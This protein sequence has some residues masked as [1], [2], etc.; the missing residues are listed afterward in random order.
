MSLRSLLLCS[1]DKVT[2]VLR[3]V[4]SDL[5]IGVEHCGDAESAVHKLTRR[6]YEAVIVDCGDD[7]VA[8]RVF[9][10]VRSAP[11]NRHAIAVALIDS[12]RDVQ[13]AFTLG[14]HFV[15]YKTIS[16]ERAKGSFRAAR[17]LMKC[18]RRR[19]TRVAI[20]IPVTLSGAEIKGQ[21]RI[22]TSDM[23]EGG[24]AIQLPRRTRKRGPLRV[25]FTLPGTD[26]A[27]DCGAEV[28]W[29]NPGLHTG[30]RFVDLSR[31]QRNCL[32]S[33]MNRHCPEIEKEDPPV[34]CKLTDVSPG[35][36][37]LKMA[38]PFP[39]RTMVLLLMR[40]ADSSVS[41]EGIVRAMHQESGMGVEF[42][43]NT[44]QQREQVEEFIRH[45]N[46]G[47]VPLELEVE[48]EGLDDAESLVSIS[49]RA[50]DDP[51]L[52]LFRRS[53]ELSPEA[54]HSELQKQRSSRGEAAEAA[55]V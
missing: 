37:Y 27:I 29:E 51:L 21:P 42:I 11:C 8:A 13:S 3:R 53:R 36:C 4:L 17:A 48:P 46:H 50:A 52:D 55:S 30:I 34:P 43:Q 26:D 32:K 5:E 31:K 10:S 19:N 1:D 25:K 9:A 40:A 33:W 41:V 16:S 28:A 15:L 54:F 24:M 49:P 20:E 14:A 39:V 23:S 45:L 2:R 38:T 44:S 35:G 6:R 22:V 12:Q 18:E 7:Q 47:G